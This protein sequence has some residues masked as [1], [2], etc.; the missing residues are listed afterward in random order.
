MAA[1]GGLGLAAVGAKKAYDYMSGGEETKV[2]SGRNPDSAILEKGSDA[3]RDKMNVNVP[4]PT[5]IQAPGQP[6]ASTSDSS[7]P[8]MRGY[9]RDDESSWMRFALKRAMA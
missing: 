6:A 8:K 9:V 2:Q 4:P 7:P 1:A 5:V 3:A